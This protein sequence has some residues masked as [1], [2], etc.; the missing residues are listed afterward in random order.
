MNVNLYIGAKMPRPVEP[1]P[2][3]AAGE[4]IA[5][6]LARAGIASRRDVER[7][8]GEGRIARHGVPLDTPATVLT[9]LDGI[10]VDGEP[11][12]APEPARL[13]LYHKPVGLLVT[14]RDPRGR[15]T[16]YDRLPK[17]LPR[18][19]P[20][21]RLDMNTEGLLLL[22]TDGGLK[23]QLEL[24]ATGVQRTYRAR[25]YGHVTQGQLES[26][27]E[28]IEIEGMRYG[29]ID[30]NMERRTGAN[31]WIEM[32]LTEGKN[33]EVRRVLEHLGLEV[34]R[35]I[36]TRYG[37][38]VLGDLPPNDIGEVRTSDLY[39]FRRTLKGGAPAA[40]IAVEPRAGFRSPPTAQRRERGGPPPASAQRRERPATPPPAAQRRDRTAA[41]P[42]AAQ[43]HAPAAKAPSRFPGG[44]RSPVVTQPVRRSTR[45][46]TVDRNSP[47][48][49]PGIRRGSGDKPR[50]NHPYPSGASR[51][52]PSPIERGKGAA[53]GGAKRDGDHD[54]TPTPRPAKIVR[55]TGWAK[56]KP[57]PG[58]ARPRKPRA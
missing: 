54:V 41:P 7:M 31:F 55:K 3:P 43:G 58:P 6:L 13:F 9:S 38:F 12:A 4:R 14:E 53:T 34:S 44:S 21:G 35:L 19:V 51:V 20:V 16:I 2:V 1:P 26:L 25:T 30:A 39:E 11:V 22:T 23:R 32:T 47:P 49:D 29:S 15:P 48:L 27:I 40:L 18:L 8:I 17:G 37:P 45:N 57:K 46:D 10:T 36:R 52:P 50:A 28:G 56:A 42:P 5:K 33:R 24:P